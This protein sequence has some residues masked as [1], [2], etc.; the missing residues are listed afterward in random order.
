MEQTNGNH[1]ASRR[2]KAQIL[3]LLWEFDKSPGIS[4]K[5]FCRLHKISEG[6]FYTA[7]KRHRLQLTS[8]QQSSGFIGITQPTVSVAAGS[9]FAEVNGIRI[10]QAVPADYLKSLVL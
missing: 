4:V 5:D 10:Y 7:R 3:E 6:S 1:P 8:N 2:S 9:L